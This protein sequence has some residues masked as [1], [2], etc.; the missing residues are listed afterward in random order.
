MSDFPSIEFRIFSLGY[1]MM[2]V[3]IGYRLRIRWQDFPS[4]S[5]ACVQAYFACGFKVATWHRLNVR[6]WAFKKHIWRKSTYSRYFLHWLCNACVFGI[7]FGRK[8]DNCVLSFLEDNIFPFPFCR[9]SQNSREGI[10][11]ASNQRSWRR[12][13][14]FNTLYY[15]GFLIVLSGMNLSLYYCTSMN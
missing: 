7:G 1:Q 2:K 6:K 10:D 3:C 11:L 12:R 9:K 4:F 13:V 15:F 8:Q 14:T 5:L